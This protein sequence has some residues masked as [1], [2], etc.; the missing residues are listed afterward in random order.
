[1]LMGGSKI[2]CIWLV[3]VRN[4]LNLLS[5]RVEIMWLANREGVVVLLKV[6]ANVTSHYL[7]HPNFCSFFIA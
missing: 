1:M 3:F 5:S 2:S 4:S 6:G 7:E